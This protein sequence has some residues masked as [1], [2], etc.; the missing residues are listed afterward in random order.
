MVDHTDFIVEHHIKVW[1]VMQHCISDV[2]CDVMINCDDQWPVMM[3]SWSNCV[4]H[5]TIWHLILRLSDSKGLL[6]SDYTSSSVITMLWEQGCGYKVILSIGLEVICKSDKEVTND[7]RNFVVGISI[8][9]LPPQRRLGQRVWII[10][11][12]RYL[13][14]PPQWMWGATVHYYVDHELHLLWFKLFA[15]TCFLFQTLI[16]LPRS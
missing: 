8:S 2:W 14:S 4:S 16:P 10:F 3:V 7:T 1:C 11:W 6:R 13:L 15:V 5:E 12:F 9:T